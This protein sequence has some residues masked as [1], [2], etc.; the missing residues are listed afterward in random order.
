MQSYKHFLKEFDK[1]L[2][3]FQDKQSEHLHCRKGCSDC[4]QAGDYPLSQ[5]ELEYLMQGYASLDFVKRK[6]IQNNFKNIKKGGTCP[7]LINNEC[8]LY[9]FR[10]IV[11]R[12]HGL[13]YLYKENFVKIPFCVNKG[14]NFSK[15]CNNDEICIVPIKEN[16]DTPSVLK[17]FS[18]GEIRNLYDWLN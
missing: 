9:D 3:K 14:L 7:F 18:Y 8:S 4:C 2:Q 1:K 16:L 17:D 13:A 15:V 12:V 5:L 11:C 6:Q 10:P